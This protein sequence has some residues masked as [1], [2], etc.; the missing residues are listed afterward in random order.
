MK[1]AHGDEWAGVLQGKPVEPE[2]ETAVVFRKFHSTCGYG[3]IALFPEQRGFG[4]GLVSSFEHAGQHGAA[5]YARMIRLTR[6]ATP[7]EYAPLLRELESAPYN[8]NLKIV[9]RRP[10]RQS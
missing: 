5:D 9:K 7:E 2:P 10:G 4:P 6:P 3:V 8:Y 1:D